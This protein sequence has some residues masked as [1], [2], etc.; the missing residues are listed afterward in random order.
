MKKVILIAVPCLIALICLAALFIVRRDAGND[1]NE[2]VERESVLNTDAAVYQVNYGCL[3]SSF[4][5]TGHVN[6]DPAE[7]ID[8]YIIGFNDINSVNIIKEKGQE[9]AKD[10]A[11]LRT[12][13]GELASGC[14]GRITDIDYTDDNSVMVSVMNYSKLY[15]TFK[16]P[17]SMYWMI[18][19]DSEAVLY[20]DEQEINASITDIG[21]IYEDEGISCTASFDGYIMPNMDVRVEVKLG[22][23]K[24]MIYIPVEMVTTVGDFSY[25]YIITNEETNETIQMELKLG[26]V[27][28]VIDNGTE[29][30]YYEILEGVGEGQKVSSQPLITYY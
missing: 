10:E 4:T 25:I 9:V 2:T 13:K 7:Y 12:D 18:S 16:I 19:Y 22:E 1:K 17:Y 20:V 11:L 21:Y 24:P 8:T 14:N 28:T 5:G 3:E 26:E 15:V 27:Y 29:F 30:N 23:T 6:S